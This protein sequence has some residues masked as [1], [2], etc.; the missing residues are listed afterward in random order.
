MVNQAMQIERENHL[1]A[2]PYERNQY[3]QGHANGYKLKTVK[4]RVGQVT[5]EV[6]Q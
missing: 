3:W 4:A 5:F 1:H 2:K 6:P